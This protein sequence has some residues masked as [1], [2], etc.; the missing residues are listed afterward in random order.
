[1]GPEDFDDYK[2]FK[3]ILDRL[4][5]AM[6]LAVEEESSEIIRRR[7]FEWEGLPTEGQT[8]AREWAAW[9]GEN[10]D[11]VTGAF[12]AGPCPSVLR[13]GVPFPPER[14]RRIQRKV[15]DA[16]RFPTD[17]GRLRLLA[18]WVMNAYK[19]GYEKGRPDPLIT[20]GS[21][22]L[23][24]PSSVAQRWNNSATQVGSGYNCGYLGPT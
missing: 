19:E 21:A 22:P 2:R 10:R 24:D 5:K 13:E 4:G 3:K 9:V 7:L 23:G 17:A 8:T 1:M 15:V 11:L 12:P 16:S 6:I 18:L 20:L 14:L